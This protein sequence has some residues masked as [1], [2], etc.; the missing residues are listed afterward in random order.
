[1]K[2]R[3]FHRSTSDACLYIKRKGRRFIFVSLFVD[4]GLAASNDQQ[5]LNDELSAFNSVYSLKRLGPVKTFLGLE[6]HR[7]SEYIMVHQSTYVR[8]L[9]E[10]YAFDS[11]SNRPVSSPMEDRNVV[12]SNEPFTDVKLYQSAVGALQYAAH[13]TRPE[14]ANAVRSVAKH[15]AA[16]TMTNWIAIKRILRY[17]S[18]SVDLG[19]VFRFGASIKFEIYS[20]ASWADDWDNG[21]STGGYVATCAGGPVSWQCKQ[22]SIVATSTTEAETLAASAA[23]KEAVGLR[24]LALELGI[25]QTSSTILH[26]DNEA[27][28]AIARNPAHRGRTRHWNVHHFYVRERVELG[29]ITLQY[30]PT[31]LNTADMFTKALPKALFLKHRAGLGM[32]SLA[33]STR[34]SVV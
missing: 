23:S 13:R 14:I 9:L 24:S 32:A 11:V 27:C 17:L 12:E 25:D 31:A 34:G 30:C 19:L 4:D 2:T 33:T 15:V 16:P 26:E 1:M 3:G 21:K 20:D 22:Q 5:F 28:I 29:D 6:F 18:T 8:G 10:T 7:T